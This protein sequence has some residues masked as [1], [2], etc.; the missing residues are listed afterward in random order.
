MNWQQKVK[1]LTVIRYA[2]DFVVIYKGLAVVQRC[3]E[4][5]SEWLKDMGLK[6]KPSKDASKKHLLKIKM[7]IKRHKYSSQ[8][9]LINEL[10]P[11]I[12]GWVKYY[13]FSDAQTTGELTRQDYLICQKLRA[14]GRHKCQ[15]SLNQ[16]H[17]KY[18]RKIGKRNGVFATKNGD[19]NP[20]RLLLHAEFGSSSTEY[21]KVKRVRPVSL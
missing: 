1:T 6:L 5:I 20:L 9:R 13:S 12:R 21:V 4:L 17:K 8:A 16:A 3:R 2:D 18:W 14:W 19:A 15:G 7:V 10:N 11:I